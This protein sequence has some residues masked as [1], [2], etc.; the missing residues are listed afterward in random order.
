MKSVS[1][2]IEDYS[3]MM[4]QYLSMKERCGDAILLFRC[5][6]FYEMFMDDAVKAAEALDIALTKKSTGQGKTVPLAGVPYHAIQNYIYRLTRK[7]YRVAICEQTEEPQKGKK[8]LNRELTR[9]ISPG[10]IIDAD[11][12]D[13]K[14]NNYLAAL[15]NGNLYGWG[16]ACI[17]VT[18]GEFRAT[19]E[20]GNESWRTI[21]AELG[22]LNPS[23]LI[24]ETANAGDA[25]FEKQIRS[26]ADC[27]IT[28]LP[29]EAFSSELFTAAGI[30]EEHDPDIKIAQ[31]ER[32]LAHAAAAAIYTYLKDNQKE[33]LQYIKVLEL[34][35]RNAYLVIDK[36]TERNLELLR[37]A[38]EGGKKFSLLG[39]IDQTVTPMG[40]RL[41]K[42]WIVR[43]LVDAEKIRIRQEV[44]RV[45]L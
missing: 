12:I 32:E 8:L 36:S 18:T 22:T 23:E 19:W 41:L 5:G 28:D 20:N 40:G 43:P 33:T 10:T 30:D 16:L 45:F 27:L 31:S 37:S 35:R 13:G 15:Y 34:Y 39:V 9:T 3:P 44:V 6:D 42:Q 2:P 21:L 4:R 24:V 29:P 11:V 1:R 26:H 25:S 14:E 38:G 7:G 17:D